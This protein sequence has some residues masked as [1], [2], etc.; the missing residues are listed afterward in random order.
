[1]GRLQQADCAALDTRRKRIIIIIIDTKIR[2]PDNNNQ[3]NARF[4][5][6]AAYGRT[7][8]TRTR[9]AE[10]VRCII[11]NLSRHSVAD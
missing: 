11:V 8:C 2:R 10:I 7:V 5:E 6:A 9:I 1:M 3:H 4:N